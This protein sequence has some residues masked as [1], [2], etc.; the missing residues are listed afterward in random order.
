[1]RIAVAYLRREVVVALVNKWDRLSW[2][3]D[4]SHLHLTAV[5]FHSIYHTLVDTPC[6]VR[7]H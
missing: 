2:Y 7:S 5:F 6:N 4:T 1:M 3:R